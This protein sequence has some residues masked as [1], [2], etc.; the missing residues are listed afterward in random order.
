M[1]YEYKYDTKANNL[2]NSKEHKDY[3]KW[4]S[5]RLKRGFCDFDLWNFDNFLLHILCDGLTEFIAHNDAYPDEF[6]NLEAYHIFIQ[7]QIIDQLKEADRLTDSFT[8]EPNERYEK[9]NTCLKTAFDN[10]SQVFWG[11]W[12]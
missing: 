4:K 5:Q 2:K 7:E 3:K 6:N 11:L 12:T 1:L 8:I 9:A 10:L